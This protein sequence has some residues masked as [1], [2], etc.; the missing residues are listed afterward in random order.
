MGF[1]LGPVV[2]EFLLEKGIHGRVEVKGVSRGL[3][4]PEAAVL[5]E[6]ARARDKEVDLGSG[7][8]ERFFTLGVE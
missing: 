7:K 4:H 1:L 3:A 8:A 6:T 2:V 5:V